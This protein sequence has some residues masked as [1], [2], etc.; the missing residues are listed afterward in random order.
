[1]RKS[2]TLNIKFGDYYFTNEN[3]VEVPML[4]NSKLYKTYMETKGIDNKWRLIK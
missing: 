1:M 2:I 3:T 4:I